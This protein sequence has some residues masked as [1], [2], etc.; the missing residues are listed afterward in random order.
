MNVD[1]GFSLLAREFSVKPG[2]NSLGDFDYSSRFLPGK[3]ANS[4]FFAMLTT[5]LAG[6]A[7]SDKQDAGGCQI[8]P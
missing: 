8:V 2:L 7:A 6:S 1:H 5:S 3:T 4:R